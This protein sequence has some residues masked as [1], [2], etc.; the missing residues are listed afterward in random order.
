MV[1]LDLYLKEIRTFLRSLVIKYDEFDPQMRETQVKPD[2]QDFLPNAYNPYYRELWGDYLTKGDLVWLSPSVSVS[3]YLVYNDNAFKTPMYVT[4]LEILR[5]GESYGDSNADGDILVAKSTFFETA[6]D[7]LLHKKGTRDKTL[8][9]LRSRGDLYN[10]LCSRYPEQRH[11]INAILWPLGEKYTSV[12]QIVAADNLTLLN[13]DLTVLSQS[14]QQSILSKVQKVLTHLKVRW[15]EPRFNYEK[16]YATVQWAMLWQMLYIAIVEQRFYNIRTHSVHPYHIKEYLESKGLGDYYPYLDYEQNAWFYRNMDYIYASRGR[17][18]ICVLLADKLLPPATKLMVKSLVLNATEKNITAN[19]KPIPEFISEEL[20]AHDVPYAAYVNGSEEHHRLFKREHESNLEPIHNDEVVTRQYNE[21]TKSMYTYAPTKLLEIKNQTQ[22]T[23]FQDKMALFF[24][25]TALA[26]LARGDI[27][28][29]ITLMDKVNSYGVLLDSNEVIPILAYC[30]L[31]RQYTHEEILDL[32]IPWRLQTNY[33]IKKVYPITLTDRSGASQ[34]FN[35]IEDAIKFLNEGKKKSEWV[36]ATYVLGV[37]QNGRIEMEEITNPNVQPDRNSLIYDEETDT[38]YRKHILTDVNGYKFSFAG[39]PD[40]INF[41]Y[42]NRYQPNL[43]NV[44]NCPIKFRDYWANFIIHSEYSDTSEVI[45]RELIFEPDTVYLD[46]N[47][48]LRFMDK[49]WGNIYK[50]MI[51]VYST[52]VNV[53]HHAYGYLYQ[54]MKDTT[55]YQ[56]AQP[57]VTFREYI[58][59]DPSSN[60]YNAIRAIKEQNVSTLDDIFEM[61]LKQVAPID[62][63]EYNTI[64]DIGSIYYRKAKELFSKLCSYNIA[65]LEADTDLPKISVSSKMTFGWMYTKLYQHYVAQSMRTIFR[66]HGMK[67]K[68]PVNITTKTTKFTLMDIK[69]IDKETE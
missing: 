17:E 57:N 23:R 34:T 47:D 19:C 40:E 39:L 58:G 46:S 14:E 20:G 13:Y 49:Q 55:E 51:D 16:Y 1:Q 6:R 4:P 21:L 31:R 59:D 67:Y 56:I 54:S 2:Y 33:A 61:V 28:Y 8:E 5:E 52:A 68:F 18:D 41:Q 37:I 10:D 27:R 65:M 42:L 60:M 35:N 50:Y 22:N 62:N 12:E 11:L 26:L 25:D 7:G 3:A 44:L 66:W 43:P 30:T 15:F 36:T 63:S 9:A 29:K 69:Y 45:L 53:E 24:L 48:V 64:P 38:W 32:P